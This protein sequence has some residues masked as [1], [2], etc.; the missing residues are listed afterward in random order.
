MEIL[1]ELP[2]HLFVYFSRE[3]LKM[4]TEKLTV[5][6]KLHIKH[7]TTQTWTLRTNIGPMYTMIPLIFFEIVI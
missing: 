4:I 7:K 3:V 5:F 2:P 6:G 1:N